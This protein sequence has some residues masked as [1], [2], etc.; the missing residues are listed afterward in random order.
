MSQVRISYCPGHF[1]AAFSKLI[2][3]CAQANS[4]RKM[5]SRLEAMGWRPS[6]DDWGSNIPV[7]LHREC[8]CSLSRA[9][10]GRIM[11]HI[12]IISCQSAATSEIV[13][14]RWWWSWAYSC[15]QRYKN[16]PDIYLSSPFKNFQWWH[17]QLC[18]VFWKSIHRFQS[19]QTLKNG[20]SH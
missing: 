9:M 4:R 5:S 19:W 16:Y 11:L 1:Q 8:N 7:L 15:M 14:R 10:D 12:I 6:V 13:K 3:Y 20:I 18:K 17:I 2:I